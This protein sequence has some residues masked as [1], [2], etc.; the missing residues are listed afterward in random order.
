LNTWAAQISDVKWS[1][2]QQRRLQSDENGHGFELELGG[3]FERDGRFNPNQVPEFVPGKRGMAL[4]FDGN[5][6][7]MVKPQLIPL[8]AW[9]LSMWIQPQSVGGEQ[10]QVLWKTY[11]SIQIAMRPDGTIEAW[12]GDRQASVKLHGKTALKNGQWYHLEFSY[13]L[14][15]A[16]L[17]LDEQVE[18]QQQVQGFR[19]RITQR[20]SIGG[21]IEVAHMSPSQNGFHGLIDE[22][23]LSQDMMQKK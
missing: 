5:D 7:A 10:N 17:S 8:G 18:D 4:R 20:T 19:E 3:M 23:C 14:S 22:V 21:A 13:D 15:H 1:F 16:R 2:E 6:V 9:R 12:F 11:E